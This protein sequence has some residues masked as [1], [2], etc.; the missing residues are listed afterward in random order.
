VDGADALYASASASIAYLTGASTTPHERLVGLVVPATGD[1]ALVVSSLEEE[2][3]RANPARVDV[4]AWDDAD[5]P[6]TFLN[7][8]S[9]CPTRA[10]SRS[11]RTRSPLVYSTRSGTS[12]MLRCFRTPR[13]R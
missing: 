6:W 10:R 12:S 13:R 9:R 1:A 3:A 8:C 4:L 5:G 2:Y 11:R 7:A